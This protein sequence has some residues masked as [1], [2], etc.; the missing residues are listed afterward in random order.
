MTYNPATKTITRQYRFETADDAENGDI[1]TQQ[2]MDVA[3]DEVVNGVNLLGADLDAQ[4][5]SSFA[6]LSALT[7]EDVSVGGFIQVMNTG[8][9]YQRTADTATDAQFDYTLDGGV[10]WYDLSRRTSQAAS[11]ALASIPNGS[12]VVFDGL[13]YKIDIEVPMIESALADL[14]VAGIKAFGVGDVRK[15]GAVMDGATDNS[16]AYSR[17]KA[18]CAESGETF[19]CPSGGTSYLET[20]ANLRGLRNVDHRADILVAVGQTV[21]FGDFAIS[22]APV[23]WVFG[24]VTDGTS[25]NIAAAP[26]TPTLW[27]EGI[28]AGVLEYGSTNFFKLSCDGS[29]GVTGSNAYFDIYIRG[30]VKK[31]LISSGTT[32]VPWNNGIRVYGGRIQQNH[33]LGSTAYRPNNI[34]FFDPHNEGHSAYS[35]AFIEI[36]WEYCSSIH[37]VGARFD[38]TQDGSITFGANCHSCTIESVYNDQSGLVGQQ[39]FPAIPV[40]DL[41]GT[42]MWFTRQQGV[43]Q[44]TPLADL[45]PSTILLATATSCATPFVGVGDSSFHRTVSVLEPSIDGFYT[46]EVYD[47]VFT[48]PMIPVD[49]DTAFGVHADF[50]GTN[51]RLMVFIYDED[52]NPITSEGAGGDYLSYVGLTTLTSGGYY[53][54]QAPQAMANMN[55]VGSVVRSEVKYIRI[56]I[57]WQ[58]AT[59]VRSA[60]AWAALPPTRDGAVRETALPMQPR[61]LVLDG[62]P[63]MGFAPERFV[64][65]DTAGKQHINIFAHETKATAAVVS[66]STVTVSDIDNSSSVAVAVDDVCGVQLVDGRTHWAKV[67]TV[68]GADVTLATSFSSDADAKIVFN[69]WVSFASLDDGEVGVTPQSAPSDPSG[70]ATVDAESRTAIT[71]LIDK[72]QSAGV[73]T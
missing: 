68:S 47:P 50:D 34:T 10:K 67:T 64:V 42:N 35:E 11:F 25:V 30:Q 9:V 43:T 46:D 53:V 19:F 14:G 3:I 5:V 23:S 48:T 2:Q 15:Y 28:K 13:D 4:K 72:L 7:S 66:G 49:L 70:G 16:N 60:G 51:A 21:E 18:Y 56:A 24:D 32:G 38:H 58:A 52:K 27:V 8:A 45:S 57:Y 36:D 22:G 17:C 6:G 40:A 44:R 37:M 71:S 59:L 63:T 41:N 65:F 12:V 26:A 69:R 54:H 73:L 61:A 31:H 1:I 62:V 33:I 29:S 55:R 20:G 39:E